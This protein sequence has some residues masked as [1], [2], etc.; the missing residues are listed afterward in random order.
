MST[1]A[2][3]SVPLAKRGGRAAKVVNYP[4]PGILDLSLY[5]KWPPRKDI[6]KPWNHLHSDPM[7]VECWRSGA[8]VANELQISRLVL[9]VEMIDVTEHL[10]PL[11]P[12]HPLPPASAVAAQARESRTIAVNR[13]AC[14]FA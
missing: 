11:P 13:P 7:D 9:E 2:V 6:E 14:W 12:P 10:P 8:L 3:P 5:G 4:V 1:A